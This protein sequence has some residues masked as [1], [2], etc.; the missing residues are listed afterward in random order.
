MRAGQ[1]LYHW[2][3]LLLGFRAPSCLKSVS[4][5]PPSLLAPRPV[6][7][8]VHVAQVGRHAPGI[9]P[10]GSPSPLQEGVICGHLVSSFRMLFSGVLHVCPGY[11]ADRR[12][13]LHGSWLWH[14]KHTRTQESDRLLEQ[15]LCQRNPYHRHPGHLLLSPVCRVDHLV[16]LPLLRPEGK[17]PRTPRLMRHA[18]RPQ[19]ASC[20]RLVCG[21]RRQ[22]AEPP[23]HAYPWPV[24]HSRSPGIHGGRGE[25]GPAACL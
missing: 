14:C 9:V 11:A 16:R 18:P 8:V 13:H 21:L 7:R 22:H 19:H 2:P 25:D 1:D 4:L 10:R 20:G 12:P 23:A 17:L 15:Q 3:R 24:R 5:L 6:S